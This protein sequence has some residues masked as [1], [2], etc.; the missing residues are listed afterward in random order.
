MFTGLIQ[1][2]GVIQPLG[3]DQFSVSVVGNK[4]SS[5]LSD[6]AVGDSVATDGVCLTVEE[7][8][9]E[10]FM[11]TASPE[12]LKR[13]T[14]GQRSAEKTENNYVN[15]ETSLRVGGKIGGH[16][17][18]GHVDGIGLLK[19]SRA[20]EK[21]WEMTFAAPPDLL[22][23]WQKRIGRYLISK[24]SIAVNGISLTVAD[25]DSQGNW[26]TAAVIPHTYAETN[27]CHLQIG[28][29]VNL[30]SDILGKYVERL[31]TPHLGDTSVQENISIDFLAEHGYI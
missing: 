14:L 7:I 22:E 5:I 10:G 16:F 24:G 23:L 26:F 13:T 19:A 29:R 17:V 12:T 30:E 8:L 27:L 1:N 3:G 25:C 31:M 21:A 4:S 15:L 28:D 18:T 20:T 6:L 9:S 11:A 2:L